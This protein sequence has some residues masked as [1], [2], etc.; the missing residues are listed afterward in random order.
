[1]LHTVYKE[2]NNKKSY[3]EWGG[4]K[5]HLVKI[6]IMIVVMIVMIFIIIITKK[7]E[8]E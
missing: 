6:I 2:I 3:S 5:A 4:I 1:M 8:T 7:R